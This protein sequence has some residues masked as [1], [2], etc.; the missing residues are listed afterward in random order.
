[1]WLYLHPP[2]QCGFNSHQVPVF[3]NVYFSTFSVYRPYAFLLC[4]D[5]TLSVFPFSCL[6]RTFPAIPPR[7]LAVTSPKLGY[8]AKGLKRVMWLYLHP[9]EQCGFNSHQVPVFVNV[10]FSTFSVYRPYAF[11]LCADTRYVVAPSPA[12]TVWVQIPPG[13]NFFRCRYKKIHLFPAEYRP[14]AFLLLY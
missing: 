7:L 13:A 8:L 14:Y 5:T 3:V 4:A 12:R 11:L 1:M 9:P 6:V 2:E 10:Y